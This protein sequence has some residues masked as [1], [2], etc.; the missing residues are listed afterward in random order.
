M[1]HSVVV[2]DPAAPAITI[3]VN[4]AMTMPVN[5]A[6]TIPPAMTM[7]ELVFVD[8]EH[9]CFV[10]LVVLASLSLINKPAFAKVVPSVMTAIM[11]T[12]AKIFFKFFIFCLQLFSIGKV[13][14]SC[15][16]SY[17]KACAKELMYMHATRKLFFINKIPR[18]IPIRR[19]LLDVF[20]TGY[21][22]NTI[23]T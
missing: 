19:T 12:A 15:C 17:Y 18:L 22:G 6:I 3:P 10:P 23:S 14:S 4:P 21:F 5:P 9:V 8:L 20:A 2:P 16:P 13:C 11:T 1:P 7:P